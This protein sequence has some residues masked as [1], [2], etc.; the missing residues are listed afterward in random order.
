LHLFSGHQGVAR[1][2]HLYIFELDD[3]FLC[4]LDRVKNWQ[5]P[6]KIVIKYYECVCTHIKTITVFHN[7][8]VYVANSHPMSPL[9]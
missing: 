1:S 8:L 3:S 9:A 7:C 5:Y 2:F 6:N 4:A